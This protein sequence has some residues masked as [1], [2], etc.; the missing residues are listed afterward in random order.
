MPRLHRSTVDNSRTNPGSERGT[1]CLRST[2]PE[3]QEETQSCFLPPSP[4]LSAPHSA[5][6]VSFA[7][8]AA[9]AARSGSTTAAWPANAARCSG[10]HLFCGARQR[11]GRHPPSP[12]RK[13]V[14]PLPLPATLCTTLPE[15]RVRERR[16][17]DSSSQMMVPHRVTFQ[18]LKRFPFFLACLCAASLLPH[19]R[20]FQQPSDMN[21]MR[22]I[23]KVDPCK[24][25]ARSWR[26]GG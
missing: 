1:Q 13:C 19:K 21:L 26:H 4:P 3:N 14:R 24:G 20:P 23:P 18:V 6:T 17:K 7:F 2:Q 10:V 11:S 12:P 16:R 22:S 25:V 15:G 8:T 9:P 5:L